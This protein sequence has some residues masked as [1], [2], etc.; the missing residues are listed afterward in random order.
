MRNFLKI[1]KGHFLPSGDNSYRP[2]LLR[3]PWLLFFLSIVLT[4][5]GLFIAGRMAEEQAGTFLSA[6]LPAEVIALTNAERM[7][8][9]GNVLAENPLLS[10]AA[11]RK[12][13]DMAARG[14]FS[15][16]GP[17]GK[18]PWTWIA[19]AG[20]GYRFDESSDVVRA[21]MASPT[22]RANIVK[23]VYKEIGIGVAQGV[24]EGV[25]A[26]FVVQYFGT[27]QASLA[28]APAP[29]ESVPAPSP[30]AEVAGAE[31]SGDTGGGEAIAPEM[32]PTVVQEEAPLREAAQTLMRANEA[33]QETTLWIIGGVAALLVVLLGLAFFI[34]IEIQPGEMLAGGTVVAL[35]ALSLVGLN[36]LMYTSNHNAQSAAAVHAL[37]PGVAVG[38]DAVSIEFQLGG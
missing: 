15:H 5:E 38:E 32:T 30:N 24:Y 7:Q 20:Y 14:Y 8:T 17:D 22:H 1:L 12:A 6:V 37:L 34:H 23:P 29:S 28:A 4:A 11:K 10:L 16:T 27:Q 2:H 31:V 25:P 35:V 13:E 19:E 33:S 36:S 26:T 18:E 21:W 9:G 3:K